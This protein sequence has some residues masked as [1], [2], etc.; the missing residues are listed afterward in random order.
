MRPILAAVSPYLLYP[1]ISTFKRDRTG[2]VAQQ[3]HEQVSLTTTGAGAPP[4]TTVL[5]PWRLSLAPR[6]PRR[7][8]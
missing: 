6:L 7:V 3:A 1:C 2:P 8:T 4:R 5:P